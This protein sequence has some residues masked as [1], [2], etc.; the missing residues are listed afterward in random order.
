[1]LTV[2]TDD[3]IIDID[4]NTTVGPKE[5]LIILDFVSIFLYFY[6]RM[7]FLHQFLFEKDIFY[8]VGSKRRMLI[9]IKRRRNRLKKKVSMKMTK[10][11]KIGGLDTLRHMKL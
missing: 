8:R 11:I 1:M 7:F 3:V 9:P 5:T 10:K 2:Q 6:R 4:G